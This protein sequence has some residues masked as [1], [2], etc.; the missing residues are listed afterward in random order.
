MEKNRIGSAS[1]SIRRQDG[2]ASVPPLQGICVAHFIYLVSISIKQTFITKQTPN[3]RG[4]TPGARPVC[5]KIDRITVI[6]PIC[7]TRYCIMNNQRKRQ[8]TYIESDLFSLRRQVGRASVPPLQPDFFPS[9]FTPH[10]SLL[11]PHSWRRRR[12]RYLHSPLST[13][14]SPHST[15]PRSLR[16]VYRETS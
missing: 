3:C 14:H 6:L 13:L 12:R 8:M 9:L 16:S 4:A 10:S 7:I 1:L 11:T 5:V 15:L 2:R